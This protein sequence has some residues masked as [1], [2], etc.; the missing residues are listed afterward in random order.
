[1]RQLFKR[2]I[3]QHYIKD[4][5]AILLEAAKS[6]EQANRPRLTDFYTRM[7]NWMRRPNQLMWLFCLGDAI[8]LSFQH[9]IV[10]FAE[11]ADDCELEHIEILIDQS[12]IEK[13]THREFWQVWLRLFLYNRSVKKPVMTI[14]QW[15]ERDHPF[16]SKF[17]RARG[18][19]DMTDLYRNNVRF[20]KS[21]DSSGIQIADIFANIC[22]RHFSGKPKYR[23]HRLLWSRTLG[24]HNSEIHYAALNES[25]CLL[26]R[27][28]IM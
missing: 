24:E 6:T 1:M 12:F 28:K 17:K 4:A 10:M 23:P 13:S 15:S 22:Y 5:E 25:V 11:P 16:N 8:C 26:M 19:I 21:D 20:G 2:D 27:P 3:A 9:A 18:V 14:K 7:A